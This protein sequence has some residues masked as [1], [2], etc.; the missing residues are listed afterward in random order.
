MKKMF[1]VKPQVLKTPEQAYSELLGN[2]SENQIVDIKIDLIDTIDD[3]PHKIH[4]DTV[5]RIAE[6]MKIYGQLEPATVVPKKNGRFDLLAGRHRR[7]ACIENGFDTLKCIIRKEDN[8]DKQRLILLATNNDRNTDYSPSELAYSYLEQMELLKKLGSKATASQ[9]AEGN[10]TNRKTV[11]KYIQLT[12]LIKPLMSRV[13]SGAITV[14]AGYEL[15]FLTTQQQTNLIN[16]LLNHSDCHITKDI[17][18]E[19]RDNPDNIYGIFFK[20]K[21]DV[22]SETEQ[23]VSSTDAE[24]IDDTEEQNSSTPS[25]KEDNNNSSAEPKKEYTDISSLSPGLKDKLC[26]IIIYQT[27]IDKEIVYGFFT[28]QDTNKYLKELSKGRFGI[29]DGKYIYSITPKQI[30]ILIDGKKYILSFSS[31]DTL[32]REYLRKYYTPKKLATLYESNEEA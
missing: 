31:V 29:S 25:N 26:N 16:F 24:N 10:N 6:S 30:E 12:K 3:Q 1:D 15:A 23:V 11:H 9:I 20:A 4:T 5:Q 18:R 27:R 28:P 32:I 21:D 14:G 8:P 19:I 22:T 2:S 13:D 7:L 17:A